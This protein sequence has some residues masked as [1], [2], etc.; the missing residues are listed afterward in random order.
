M[1]ST[2]APNTWHNRPSD[3]T[4]DC[5][6]CG[7]PAKQ[8][9]LHRAVG[10]AEKLKRRAR[11]V[12]RW[13]TTANQWRYRYVGLG[14]Q[15]TG[16]TERVRALIVK[17]AT[18]VVNG[19]TLG[20]V[21]AE[22][23]VTI[24]SLV[25]WQQRHREFWDLT[26]DVAMESTVATVRAWTGT[27]AIMEDPAHFQRMAERAERWLD[28][29]GETLFCTDGVVTLS[30][31][32]ADYYLP[33]CTANPSAAYLEQAG[34]ILKRWRLFTGDPPLTEITNH[35]LARYRDTLAASRGVQPG[36][37]KQ[38]RT[39]ANHLHFLQR[40]LDKSG[41]V[42]R[43]NRDG[44]GILQTVPWTKPPR[45]PTPL[46]QIVASE[47]VGLVYE[48]AG[49]MDTPKIP[50]VDPAD[51]WQALIA[52]GWNTGMRRGTI[53]ELEMADV[54]WERRCLTIPPERLKAD[55][56]ETIHLN[57]TAYAHLE[58]IRGDRKLVFPWPGHPRCFDLRF[59]YVQDLAGI[60][61]KDHFGLQTLRRTA[62]TALHKVSPSAARLALCHTTLA[63]TERHYV[64][65]EG[66]VA[67]GLDKLPQPEAFTKG[68]GNES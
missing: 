10:P 54:D 46:P 30:S 60:P 21:A 40:L 34:V 59:H 22:L 13:K 32:W 45:I 14:R 44:A 1:T 50:G 33:N 4:G 31:F 57:P 58:R 9:G 11:W 67:E 51:W 3:S 48:V 47:V 27:D 53:F 56:G 26:T 23:S 28:K 38:P 20:E 36:T 7:L 17:A 63:V 6:I 52:I 19:R 12:I 5:P 61:R 65:R 8:H 64:Q 66:A 29:R 2:P 42:G 62:G 68:N 39:V 18:L 16:P 49:R 35:I 41:P 24:V 15:P 37:T 43:Y 55:R 25:D